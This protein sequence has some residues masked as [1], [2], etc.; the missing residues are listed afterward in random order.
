LMPLATMSISRA[1][2]NIL[3]SKGQGPAFAMDL[4]E[5]PLRPL[6]GD[7]KRRVGASNSLGL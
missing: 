3:S 6:R 2:L 5:M 7:S 4:R 1:S